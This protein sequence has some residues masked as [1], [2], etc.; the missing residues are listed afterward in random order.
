MAESSKS[1]WMWM[2]GGALV[3]GTVA[4]LRHR[5]PVGTRT[6]EEIRW[7][8]RA[9]RLGRRNGVPSATSL[10][11]GECLGTSGLVTREGFVVAFW[12]GPLPLSLPWCWNRGPIVKYPAPFIAYRRRA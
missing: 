4:I 5:P 10:R 8:K 3:V 11:P 7:Y 2:V 9:E 1:A 6:P 12:K